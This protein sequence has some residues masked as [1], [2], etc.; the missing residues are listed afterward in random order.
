MST[1]SARSAISGIP[2]PTPGESVTRTQADAV[3]GDGDLDAL[4]V[5][6]RGHMDLA[7]AFA[8]T[9]GVHDGIRHGL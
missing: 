3:V 6:T 8:V 1:R 2:S 9:V 4:V 7:G 5:Q